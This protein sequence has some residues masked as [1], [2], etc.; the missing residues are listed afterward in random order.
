ME[1]KEFLQKGGTLSYP[2]KR[3]L[4]HWYG[5]ITI[6]V[7]NVDEEGRKIVLEVPQYNILSIDKLDDAIEAF[8]SIAMSRDNIHHVQ[9][10]LMQKFGFD[11]VRG[12]ETELQDEMKKLGYRE[13]QYSHPY[14]GEGYVITESNED[15]LKDEE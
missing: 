10:E 1:I 8:L 9:Q 13:D 6:S 14:D 3:N 12:Y 15:F 11:D 5:K 2:Y 4:L 7:I